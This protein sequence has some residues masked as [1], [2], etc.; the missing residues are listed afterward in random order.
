MCVIAV[1]SRLNWI[2]Y[3]FCISNLSW[4]CK[5]TYTKNW[6]LNQHSIL[7]AGD[8]K[9]IEAPIQKQKAQKT[10][11]GLADLELISPQQPP[12]CCAL[13]QQLQR[14][15]KHSSV[16]A[17]AEHSLEAVLSLFHTTSILIQLQVR[18]SACHSCY[19]YTEQVWGLVTQKPTCFQS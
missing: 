19:L 17:T 2:F 11:L 5:K 9:H 12:Q 7:S 8:G 3:L 14:C 15:W 16:L 13:Q 18:V 4:N 6:K 1:I 10:A